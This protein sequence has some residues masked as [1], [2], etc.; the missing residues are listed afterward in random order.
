MAPSTEFR[1]STASRPRDRAAEH[2]S[3]S[4]GSRLKLVVR[5]AIFWS[6]ER[7]SWQYD[8]I[9]VLILAFIFLT[10]VSWFHDRPR[11]QLSDLRHVQGIVEVSHTNQLWL[12]QLDARLVESL[13]TM[14]LREAIHQLLLQRV[15][16]PFEIESIKPLLGSGDVVLG[17]TVEVKR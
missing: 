2:T 7:G 9:C 12:Y 11:L 4:S 13:G 6:Y 17:Y 14:P 5:R 1:E 8:I 16:P 10:P 15:K 3:P